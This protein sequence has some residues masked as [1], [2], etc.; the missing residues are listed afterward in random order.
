MVIYAGDLLRPA[1]VKACVR[2]LLKGQR[3]DG[4]MPDRVTASGK[5][6]YG[7]GSEQHPLAD[8]ALDNGPFMALLVC[9]YARRY[10]DW[11]LFRRAEPA[12]RR[13]LDHTCR[14]E[15]GLIYNPPEAPQCPYGFA[16]TVAKTGHLLFCSLLY[17][18]ACRQM[19]AACLRAGCG[20]PAEYQRR[21][22]LIRRN[23]GL[24]WNERA[25]MFWAADRDCKQI[26]IWGS[27]LAA[28]SGCAS[29]EQAGRIADYLVK[30]YKEVVQRGQVRHLPGGQTW[31]RLLTPI[32]PGVYQNGGYWAT[33]AAWVAPAIARRDPDLAVRMVR[34][35]IA[36]FRSHNIAEWIN[37]PRRGVPNYVASA[38]NV[39]FLTRRTTSK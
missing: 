17:Y 8:H 34:D 2:F 7:P 11:A 38:T 12:L 31:Q 27:A 29:A 16:D 36:D 28:E 25:G 9:A 26:D 21:A 39:Y 3:A 22:E 30:H 1:E 20:E 14:A 13:G 32:A 18:D 35:A 15:N 4:C 24:L 33:P 6:V 5:P 10:G 23:I 37:G 19:A